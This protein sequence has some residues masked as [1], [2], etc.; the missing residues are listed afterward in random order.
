[1]A[2]ECAAV[3]SQKAIPAVC[4]HRCIKNNWFYHELNQRNRAN[5][6]PRTARMPW[7][8]GKML[9]NA[10]PSDQPSPILW[11]SECFGSFDMG[12]SAYARE[13]LCSNNLK[14][15]VTTAR[16]VITSVDHAVISQWWVDHI[17][18]PLRISGRDRWSNI[19]RLVLIVED[20]RSVLTFSSHTCELPPVNLTD[21]ASTTYIP[22]LLS[23]NT[24]ARTYLHDSHSSV[25]Y[26]FA[27][28]LANLL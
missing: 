13:E 28:Y 5:T 22:P 23:E 20:P 25:R 6:I 17:F 19:K 16:S 14:F 9:S 12:G 21:E 7:S 8:N 2:L 1:M 11:R 24:N 4:R 26:F 18:R 15:N 27:A 10:A 3:W